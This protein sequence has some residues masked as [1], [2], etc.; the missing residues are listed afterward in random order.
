MHAG[1]YLRLRC[2]LNGLGCTNA[3]VV[4]CIE[5]TTEQGDLSEAEGPEKT[6]GTERCGVHQS[7]RVSGA[8]DGDR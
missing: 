5:M 4:P 6:S 3:Y 8:C 7:L 2:R 1:K